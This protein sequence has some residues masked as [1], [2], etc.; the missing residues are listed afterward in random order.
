MT[1]SIFLLL[2]LITSCKN[3]TVQVGDVE[4]NELYELMQGSFNSETQA[5]ADST[6]YN[7]SLHMYPIWKNKGHY[8][9][10]EQA[11][12]TMQEKPY[13]Q[14]VY[15][16]SRVNDSLFKSA[17]YKLP[18][19]SLW[20]GKWNDSNAF[21]TLLP[22]QLTLREGCDVYLERLGTNHYKGATGNKT[23][24]STLRGASYAMSS[25]EIMLGS[26][27]SWDRG[28]DA[29]DNHVW[30]AEKAGYIFEKVKQ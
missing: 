25:V 30:G 13:R 3:S 26:V 5:K 10:V 15:E 6:Y 20:I 9:Y 14:R 28:F 23:C 7:I 16:L 22:D 4:L 27:R 17:I 8:L 2:I 1:R 11:I 24:K 18:N 29:Q 19:D 12:T 21:I